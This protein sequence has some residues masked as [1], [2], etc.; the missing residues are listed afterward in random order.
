MG[1]EISRASYYQKSLRKADAHEGAN[2]YNGAIDTNEEASTALKDLLTNLEINNAPLIYQVT[3]RRDVDSNDSST[4]YNGKIDPQE[5]DKAIQTLLKTAPLNT[6][7]ADFVYPPLSSCVYKPIPPQ[8]IPEIPK[9]KISQTSGKYIAD[10]KQLYAYFAS[11]SGDPP[12]ASNSYKIDGS[13][14]IMI[15]HVYQDAPTHIRNG[16]ATTSEAGLA[17]NFSALYAGITGEAQLF[18]GTYNYLRYFMMPHDGWQSPQLPD[19]RLCNNTY[20]PQGLTHWLID[21]SGHAKTGDAIF[22]ENVP[23]EVY[24]TNTGNPRPSIPLL[25]GT[26][27]PNLNAFLPADNNTY[28]FSSALDAD[29]WFVNGYYFATRYLP[30]KNFSQDISRSKASLVDCLMPDG[31]YKGVMRFG[32][33]WGANLKEGWGWKANGNDLYAGYQDPAVWIIMGEPNVANNIVNFLVDAQNMY[34][35]KYGIL[36]PFMPVYSEK[37]EWGWKGADPNTQ[38][39][40]F[41]Y[42]AFAHLAFYYYL[43]GDINAKR[44]LDNFVKWV[45]ANKKTSGS[46]I[47]IPSVLEKD[48]GRI[49]KI[50]YTPNDHGLL[51]QG[52]IFM[53]AKSNDKRCRIL[54]EAL[55]DDLV[56]NRKNEM[57]SYTEPSDG[58]IY[59]FHQAEVGIALCLH[60]ILLKE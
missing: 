50:G 54:A 32:R 57:G 24:A 20:A 7:L 16:G 56:Q 26:S 59:G 44:V 48:S 29:Q 2:G 36:G 46:E 53:A 31:K 52:L 22:G 40:G 58:L 23:Y 51:A 34:K 11:N 49:A 42:R 60:Q 47:G 15:Y 25:E 33:Y 17:L 6:V 21:L 1:I 28:K 37:G 27:H 5:V 45:E 10:I 55:L 35:E 19:S 13:T 30:D 18:E 43:T 4:G 9:E 14:A 41:Q 39:T 8:R 3:L 12:N 38:W